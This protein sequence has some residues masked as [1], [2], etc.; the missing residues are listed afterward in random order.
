LFFG[1]FR[2][3]KNNPLQVEILSVNETEQMVETDYQLTGQADDRNGLHH[4]LA[5]VNNLVIL[6]SLRLIF[7][8]MHD[9]DFS[10]R[11]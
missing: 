3:K 6:K 5:P 4:G 11:S 10:A 1:A 7:G 8:G 2:V 9:E